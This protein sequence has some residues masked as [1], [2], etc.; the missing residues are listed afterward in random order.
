MAKKP[1]YRD[2]DLFK[3]STMTFGEHLEELRAAL[4]KAI[5]GMVLAFVVVLL[6]DYAEWPL[7]PNWAVRTMHRP[8]SE[9]LERF[10]IRQAK[11][12][13]ETEL[14]RFENEGIRTP[15]ADQLASLIDADRM[16]PNFFRL[17]LRQLFQQLREVHGLDV[18]SDLERLDPSEF[19]DVKS[20]CRQ[21]YAGQDALSRYL[22]EQFSP[23]AQ[24]IITQGATSDEPLS[25][26]QTAVLAREL[27]NKVVARKDFYQQNAA[28]F[29]QIRDDQPNWLSRFVDISGD[30]A[31]RKRRAEKATT[32][33]GQLEK[34]LAEP[35]D[36]SEYRDLNRQLLALAYPDAIAGSARY[37]NLVALTLWQRVDLD[38]RVSVKSLN[39]QEMF[40]IWLKA[41]ILVSLVIASPWVF[42]QIWSFVAAGLYPH[43]KNYVHI[44]LPFSVAL[45]VS[46]AALCFFFVFK[47]VLD[48]LFL[49]NEWMD[50]DPDMRI[51]EWFG[52]AL[53]LP[54]GFGV[55]FQ[56]PLVML[57][58][59]RIGVMSV[60]GY[61]S[62]WRISVLVI[63]VA[64]AILTPADPYSMLLMAIPLV[65]LYFGGIAMCHYLPRR[66]SA[67]EE[68]ET[69]AS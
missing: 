8:L 2:E 18:P 4:F 38:P 64:S 39:A 14:E 13:M 15:P 25:P 69:G 57:F 51:N 52:F 46:G 37:K 20:F 35:G 55:A 45:F 33:A 49:F 29:A 47:Y 67:F 26:K 34:A 31:R 5:A 61:L 3:D 19:L 23:E 42:Y 28:F 65:F 43:E 10:Y 41:A 40:M 6:L 30:A 44:Y 24:A 58:L 32:L 53:L 12:R 48:F 63:C 60:P 9:A 50:I 68:D 59:E 36:G 66:R 11:K 7:G 62:K 21:V 56:L 27:A 22:W 17:D 54:V 16:T 1:K